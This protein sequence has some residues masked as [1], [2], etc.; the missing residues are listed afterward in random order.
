MLLRNPFDHLR[1]AE[2]I[3]LTGKRAF[4]WKDLTLTC[5]GEIPSG[6]QSRL[7]KGGA[8]STE[9]RAQNPRILLPSP[10]NPLCAILAAIP[11]DE[12]ASKIAAWIHLSLCIKINLQ[13]ESSLHGI[14]HSEELIAL[15]PLYHPIVLRSVLLPVKVK[16]S[17]SGRCNLPALVVLLIITVIL[18]KL[19]WNN[20]LL[21]SQHLWKTEALIKRFLRCEEESEMSRLNH[22]LLNLHLRKN[23]KSSVH[24]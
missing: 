17:A 15:F 4:Y 24:T 8:L 20:A 10:P 9:Q 16:H 6:W 12:P 22:V 5:Q 18:F 1:Q 3:F 19:C 7:Q 21:L 13:S 2:N 14:T 23:K 11:T